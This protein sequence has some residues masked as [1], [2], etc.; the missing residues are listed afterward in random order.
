MSEVD[1]INYI[2]N[3]P[4]ETYLTTKKQIVVNTEIPA[5]KNA[6]SIGP[7]EVIDGKTVIVGENSTYLVI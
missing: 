3:K 6:V 4:D 7:I 2:G 5:N 1:R